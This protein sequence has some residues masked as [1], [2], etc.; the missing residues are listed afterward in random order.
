MFSSVSCWSTSPRP[1]DALRCLAVLKP[2]GTITVIEGDHGRPISIP[3]TPPPR[4][5]SGVRSTLQARAGGNSLIGRQLYPLMT[6]A[7]F[8]AVLAAWD[9]VRGLEPHDLVEAS[10]EKRSPR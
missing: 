9:G 8:G 6:A 5:R 4:R 3:T 10:R 7:G 2:G 1:S